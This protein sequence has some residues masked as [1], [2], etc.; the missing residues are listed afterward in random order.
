MKKYSQKLS[1]IAYHLLSYFIKIKEK[2]E[3]KSYRKTWS[4]SSTILP[5]MIGHTLAIYNG[6]K[7]IPLSI[8]QKHI[9]Y[10]LGEFSRTRTFYE[11]R[12]KKNKKDKKKNEK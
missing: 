3:I 7:H 1:Y 11:H 12:K 8:S 10:K 4:R 9:G 2:L 5:V 6:K